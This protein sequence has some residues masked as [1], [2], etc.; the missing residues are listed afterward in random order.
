MSEKPMFL[1][2]PDRKL[3]YQQVLGN[4]D[5]CSKNGLFFLGGYASDMTGSK[6][7][8]LAERSAA[9]GRG[10]TRFDYS[11]HGQ[12]SG[13]FIDG[14]IGGWFQDALAVFDQLTTGPQVLVGSSMGGWIG[15]LLA[16]ARPERVAGFV[17]IAAAP[18]FT[19][20]LIERYLSPEQQEDLRRDG[21]TYDE[22]GGPERRVPITQKLI[23]EGRNHLLLRGQLGVDCPMRLLQG[24]QDTEVPWQ[25]ALRITETVAA[26]DVR[27]TLI[28]DGNHSLSRPEDLEVLWREVEG[29]ADS[30]DGVIPAKAGI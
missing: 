17:G 5:I 10:L 16:R 9:A 26:Q 11:G 1:T 22:S 30:Y 20:D 8:F 23:D 3:A 14:T 7:T 25:T 6:A 27:V 15:L 29:L 13:A 2:L 12:S 4:R 21:V 18:D 24:L 28:K 19:V